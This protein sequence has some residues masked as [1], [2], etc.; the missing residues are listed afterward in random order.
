[1]GKVAGPGFVAGAGCDLPEAR[2]VPGKAGKFGDARSGG[3][4]A[5]CPGGGQLPRAAA[6]GVGRKKGCRRAVS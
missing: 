4:E 6:E 5:D 3:G 2:A 1:M